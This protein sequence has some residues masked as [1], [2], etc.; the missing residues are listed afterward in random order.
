MPSRTFTVDPAASRLAV[1][2][3]AEGLLARLAHD[4]ELSSEDLSG[5][6]TLDGD[7][8]T[9]EIQASAA[10]LRVDGVIRGDTMDRTVLSASERDEIERRMRADVFDGAPTLAVTAQGA[11][12][13]AGAADVSIGH[14]RTR[15]TF[16]LDAREIEGGAIVA[17]GRFT[18]SLKSLGAK[19][20][21]GPL[22]AFS[23][24]DAV[25]VLFEL[26]LREE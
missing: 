6:A 2:T 3:R 18:L 23:V 10:S 4:L 9:A 12:R 5:R 21:K 14:R 24:K 22:G 19:P 20:I 16:T 7:A 17:T 15:T 11:S 26:T 13:A 8:W 25:Q 1:G